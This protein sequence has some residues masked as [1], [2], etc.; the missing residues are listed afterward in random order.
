MA[1]VLF[2]GFEFLDVAAPGELLGAVPSAV[3]LLYCAEHP[4]PIPSSCMELAGGTVGP[5]LIATHRLAE[6]GLL[7]DAADGEQRAPFRPDAI[8]IPGGKGMR[9][10]INNVFLQAWLKEAA[11]NADAVLTVCTGSWLLAAT[12]ALDGMPAT[13]NKVAMRSGQPQKAAPNVLWRMEARWVE[14][15]CIRPSGQ[16]TLFVTSSGVSAGGDAALA[17]LARL[18]GLET[19]RRLAHRVE[20]NWHED[21]NV[22]PFAMD[23]NADPK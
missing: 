3:R 2:P 7:V 22:D 20:W 4:G 16:T 1:V 21:P 15:E 23:F 19:A 12:G 18:V 10:E 13:S 17:L 6:G 14:Y 5:S 8:F 9:V 11:D